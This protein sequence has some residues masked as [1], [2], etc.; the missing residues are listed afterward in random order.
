VSLDQRGEK[1]CLSLHSAAALTALCFGFKKS[2][3][4]YV[5]S[6]ELEDPGDGIPFPLSLVCILLPSA[7]SAV[8]KTLI[9]MFVMLKDVSAAR[10][11]L[12]GDE[13]FRSRG[14]LQSSLPSDHC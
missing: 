7:C 3:P 9:M 5:V 8:P 4:C 2:I 14:L 13:S 10:C 11:V 6:S 12:P 1:E